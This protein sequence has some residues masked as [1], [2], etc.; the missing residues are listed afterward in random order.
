MKSYF[1]I[2]FISVLLIHCSDKE[3]SSSCQKVWE[4]VAK[5]TTSSVN[6][7]D[8]SL[9]LSLQD[10][11]TEELIIQQKAVEFSDQDPQYFDLEINFESFNAGLNLS[12]DGYFRVA[13]AYQETPNQPIYEFK[14]HE[15]WVT[16]QVGENPFTREIW[17]RQARGRILFSYKHDTQPTTGEIE[18]K[19]IDTTQ[20]LVGRS[21]I[22]LSN[23]PLLLTIALGGSN[24]TPS[25]DAVSIAIPSIK[26]NS[27]LTKGDIQSD[28]F[29]CNSIQ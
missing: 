19:P 22:H 17:N 7:I 1:N 13:I 21:K 29:E 10:P 15:K 14:M 26:F 20:E 25:S 12:Y 3:D 23:K 8:G 5:P 9:T 24:K 11:G 27:S 6:V 18:F 4:V 16:F 28:S 2:L